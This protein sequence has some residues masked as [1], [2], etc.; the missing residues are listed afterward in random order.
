MSPAIWLCIIYLGIHSA[1]VAFGRHR[2]RR[3]WLVM[4][5]N[6]ALA[7]AFVVI[8]RWGA[9]FPR[10]WLPVAFFW[11]AYRWAELTLG[12]FHPPGFSWDVRIIPLERR[13]FGEASLAAA[14]KAPRWVTEIFHFFYFTYY[15]YTPALGI[16]LYVQGRFREFEAMTFAVLFGYLVSY[17]FYSLTPVAGP[18]WALVDAGLLQPSEQRLPGYWFTRFFNVL[19]YSKVPLKGGAMP[20]A[21]S[22]TGIVFFAWCWQLWGTWGAIVAAVTV[23]GM[24]LGSVYGRYHY[25]LD[26]LCGAAIGALSLW[27]AAL[28]VP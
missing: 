11:A 16:F 9:P 7:A 5:V 28:V 24:W 1:L 6:A 23:A 14:R 20:S 13:L 4:T 10:L 17:I 27:L 22:S 8:S 2:P 19:M 12:A 21:H 25:V 18:R 26:I 3:F 15:L